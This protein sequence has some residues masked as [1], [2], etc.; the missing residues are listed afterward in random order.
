MPQ[1]SPVKTG[2]KVDSATRDSDSKDFSKGDR[3]IK[4]VGAGLQALG[5]PGLSSWESPESP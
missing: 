2:G 4:V 1:H 3:I 5:E